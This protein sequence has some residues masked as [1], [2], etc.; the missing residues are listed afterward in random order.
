VEVFDVEAIVLARDFGM[1]FGDAVIAQD[2][3]ASRIPPED[4][5]L[6]VQRKCLARCLA[7]EHL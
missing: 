3:L 2:D 6:F 5:N 1:P 4:R 7:L